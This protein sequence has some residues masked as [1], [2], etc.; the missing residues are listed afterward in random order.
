MRIF[1]PIYYM[2]IVCTAAD[3][4][5]H[6]LMGEAREFIRRVPVKGLAPGRKV[7]LLSKGRSIGRSPS[8]PAVRGA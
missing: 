3:S 4:D 1:G 2:I 8:N 5:S 7:S 6:R